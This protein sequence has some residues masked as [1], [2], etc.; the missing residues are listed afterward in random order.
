MSILY[1]GIRRHLEIYNRMSQMVLVLMELRGYY[2]HILK[3]RQGVLFRKS[4]LLWGKQWESSLFGSP[5]LLGL[6]AYMARIKCKY[7]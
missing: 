6:S 7:H 5:S 4:V 1:Q 2:T 3:G